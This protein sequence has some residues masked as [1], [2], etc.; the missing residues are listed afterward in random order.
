[1]LCPNLPSGQAAYTQT[2]DGFDYGNT[3]SGWR[4]L[5]DFFNPSTKI[6]IGDGTYWLTYHWG[7][8]WKWDTTALNSAAQVSSYQLAPRHN[9]GGNFSYVDGHGEYVSMEDK[10]DYCEDR[11][12]WI[13]NE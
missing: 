1:M 7:G 8:K 13:W 5:E 11:K 6:L 2:D 10:Y 9:W 12:T 3:G 4:S